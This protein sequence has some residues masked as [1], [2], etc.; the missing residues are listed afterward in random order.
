MLDHKFKSIHRNYNDIQYQ[1][2]I[3]ANLNE[4]NENNVIYQS[5]IQE[6]IQ[7]ATIAAQEAQKEGDLTLQ[8]AVQDYTLELQKY[9]AE[10]AEYQAEVAAQTQEQTVKMQQYQL[11]YTQLKA[12]YDAAFMIAAP[13]QQ[14]QQQVRA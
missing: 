12:E 7:N 14:P 5:T 8:A 1:L 6:A 2:D 11:L 13:K 10:I 9:Q 4:F 3:Q